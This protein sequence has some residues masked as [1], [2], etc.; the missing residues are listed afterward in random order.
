MSH[1]SAPIA[2]S[3][4]PSHRIGRWEVRERLASGPFATVYAGR[5]APTDPSHPGLS[6]VG[7]SGTGSG[8][9]GSGGAGPSGTD[10][11]GL[12]NQVALKFLLPGTRTPR[13][14][15]HLQD[16][17]A[18]ERE[19]LRRLRRPRLLRMYESLTVDGLDE[20]LLNGATVLVLERAECSLDSLL[21]RCPRPITGPGFLAQIC[22]GLHQL[23]H[24]GWVHGDLKPTNVLLLPDH[25]IR[26]GDFH[27]ATELH[28]THG[29]ASAFQT[30][31]YTPPELLW[32]H[33]GEHGRRI[34]TTADIWAFGVLAHL[35]LTGTFPLPG[36]TP[37]ARRDTAV[38][39]AR[40]KGELLLSPLLPTEWREIVGDCLAR[41][42][43][44]RNRLDTA[45]LLRRVESA[46]GIAPSPPLRR[47]L[48]D[49]LGYGGGTSS[50]RVRERGR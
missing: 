7:L 18:R 40:G 49:L 36:A 43:D 6:A 35:V 30:T 2:L 26:L 19:V 23:H 11:A 47:R 24:A 13:Q 46:A 14:L 50:R 21:R 39:Y 25:S 22:E 12:P 34:G 44:E 16:L 15:R 45:G 37:G 1:G 3:V 28:G 5:L 48:Q 33:R 17:V 10:S 32:A 29:Y 8:G 27:L 31:D 38:R 42:H 20:P 41:T 4:P 9:A